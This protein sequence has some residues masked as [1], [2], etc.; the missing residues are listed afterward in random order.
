MS[1]MAIPKNLCFC[2]DN[3]NANGELPGLSTIAEDSEQTLLEHLTRAI[4]LGA[5]DISRANRAQAETGGRLVDILINLGICLEEDVANAISDV[6]PVPRVDP[7]SIP[8]EPIS[9]LDLRPEFL[10]SVKMIPL[11]ADEGRIIVAMSD[12]LNS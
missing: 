4:Q 3:A 2:S 11:Q 9:D 12:P 10:R 5:S 8:D 1:R 7:K 6:M